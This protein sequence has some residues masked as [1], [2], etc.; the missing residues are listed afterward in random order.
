M[1][2]YREV[3]DDQREEFHHLL[4]YAFRPHEEEDSYDSEEDFWDGV[5]ERR[6][7]YKDRELLA[8]SSIHE[9]SSH[10][11]EDWLTVGGISMV[12]TRP[13]NRH[14]GY[15]R[16]MMGEILSELRDRGITLSALWPFSYP[17][18]NRLGWRVCD[19]SHI[20]F[21][22]PEELDF[23]RTEKLGSFRKITFEE[24]EEIEPLYH[25]FARQF[26]LPLR[27]TSDWWNNRKFNPWKER[28]YCYLWE[29]DGEAKG[30]VLYSLQ[31]SSEDEW[32]KDLKVKELVYR[33]GET[34]YQLLR[35]LYNHGSQV[36]KVGV[37]GPLPE[38]LTLLDLVEDPRSVET[39]LNP[40]V[41]FRIVDVE[42]ALES[43]VYDTGIEGE[44]TFEITDSLLAANQG[45]FTLN[46]S[47]DSRKCRVQHEE[48]SSEVD[49]SL[50]IGSLA[51]LY[52][53]YLSPKQLCVSDNMKVKNKNKLPLLRAAFLP[54]ETYFND[55]F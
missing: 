33:D 14:Q 21:L 49:F 10:I 2:T 32:K 16:T 5:G 20:Y 34:F 27:R 24:Y 48:T 51:Q 35:F 18:Y 6:G 23:E 47:Q 3:P 7:I 36:K 12:A 52:T 29:N 43:L 41:M 46:F 45:T 39:E 11:R 53:G 22:G 30:Y 17:F 15:I 44:I 25:D 8:I 1:V 28:S 26:N 40:G 19:Q 31:E 55:G 54:Q 4:H 13:E 42:A 38:N 9:L 50:D 37:P